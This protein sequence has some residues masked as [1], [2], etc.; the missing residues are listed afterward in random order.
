MWTAPRSARQAPHHAH[1]RRRSWRDEPASGRSRSP[2]DPARGAQPAA[3]GGAPHARPGA[4]ERLLARGRRASRAGATL[5]VW[6]LERFGVG[7]A[8]DCPAAPYSLLAEGAD[9]EAHWWLRADPVHVEVNRDSL[10]IADATLFE[11]VHAEAESLVAALDAHFAPE[12]RFL[13]AQ[14]GRWYVRTAR[15]GALATTPV[16]EARGRP[17]DEHLPRG[18]DAARWNALLNEAQMLLHAHPVNEAREARGAP[19][20]NSV[21]LWGAG[22]YTAPARVPYGCVWA[23]DPLARGLAQSAGAHHAPLPPSAPA[24]LA[25]AAT[26]G[27]AA[28]VLDALRAPAAYGDL[29]AWRTALDALERD[30]FAALLAA[31][32]SGR[33]GMITLHV[34][35]AGS[36]LEAETTRQD[37]RYL[38]RRA[39]PLAAYAQ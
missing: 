20:V 34:P 4:L 14:P 6:L 23:D 36:T 30:W 17:A 19:T 29:Q 1:R 10:W 8:G 3:R 24:L 38:W 9:P 26:G 15:P 11:L 28:V 16:A 25:T 32:R 33:I 39:R 7:A 18:A 21:W 37:L 12:V 2:L 31:L 27:V 22:R 13:A 5:E 35:A